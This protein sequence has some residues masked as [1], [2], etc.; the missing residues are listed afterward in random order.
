MRKV[1]DNLWQWRVAD[2]EGHWHSDAFFTGDINLL[3]ET[4]AG[5]TVWLIVPGFDVV[6]ERC[7]ADIK[8]RRQLIQTLPYEL[9]E[10]IIDPVEHLHFAFGDIEGDTITAAYG[11]RETLLANIEEIE[12]VGCEVQRCLVDYLQMKREGNQWVLLLE[13]DNLLV[14]TEVGL[15]FTTELSMVPHYLEALLNEG[16]PEG[17]TLVADDDAGLDQLERLLPETL[18]NDANLQWQTL[19]GCYWDLLN[20]A[21]APKMDFRS[22]ALA[23]KLPFDKWWATWK[24]PLITYAAAF[25]VVLVLTWIAQAQTA[26]E[27][28]AVIARTDDIYREVVPDGRITD[29]GRQLRTLLGGSGGGGKTSNAVELITAVAPAIAAFDDVVIRNFRYNADNSQLQMSVEAKSFGTFESLRS[30]IAEN[31]FEVEIKSANVYGDVHQ[32]QMRVK[33]QS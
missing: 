9:E 25:T 12:A 17:L 10:D 24:A 23:R 33:T 11:S 4:I 27:Q 32:A 15:G 18:R 29:P 3:K 2:T 19:Q 7:A 8:D 5:Q 26:K 30:K 13:G 21:A 31:G 20:P 22:G 14:R 28:K 1:Q 16:Q 6:T